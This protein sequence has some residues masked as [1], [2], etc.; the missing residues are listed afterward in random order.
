MEQSSISGSFANTRLG[1]LKRF[2]VS[3]GPRMFLNETRSAAQ[4]SAAGANM[5]ASDDIK[6]PSPTYV[7]HHR[8]YGWRALAAMP[9]TTGA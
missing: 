2:A 4:K 5:A 9:T 6:Q 3:A 1:I 7:A 8:K